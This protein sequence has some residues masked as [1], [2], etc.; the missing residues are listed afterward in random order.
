[1]PHPSPRAA[2]FPVFSTLASL[3]ISPFPSVQRQTVRNCR[4]S[5]PPLAESQT[6]NEDHS[7][8]FVLPTLRWDAQR[9]HQHFSMEFFRTRNQRILSNQQHLMSLKVLLEEV[10]LSPVQSWVG[11]KNWKHGPDFQW[12]THNFSASCEWGTDWKVYESDLGITVCQWKLRRQGQAAIL[13]PKK[14][15][16]YR[17]QKTSQ[18]EGNFVC[19]RGWYYPK[20]SHSQCVRSV[21]ILFLGSPGGL[22]I[23][24]LPANAGDMGSIPGRERSLGE[25]NGNPLQ[26]SCLGNL[27]NRGAW[28]ATVHGIS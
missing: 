10:R 6:L 20:D 18:S 27:M 26:Y 13:V 28:Q 15:P 9:I 24:N 2:G 21:L 7:V 19:K 16:F 5:F 23:K 22:A 25:G 12:F 17:F 1:M 4:A 8:K 3:A 11:D 14:G